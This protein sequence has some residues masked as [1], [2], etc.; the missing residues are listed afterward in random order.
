MAE[1]G[2]ERGGI[3]RP[4]HYMVAFDVVPV[5]GSHANGDFKLVEEIDTLSHEAHVE[6]EQQRMTRCI[7]YLKGI[8]KGLTESVS[9]S[10]RP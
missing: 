1:I 7:G 4:N 3:A 8:L 9:A 2:N 10:A 6:L 5:K